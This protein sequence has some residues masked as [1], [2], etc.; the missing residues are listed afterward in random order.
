MVPKTAGAYTVFVSSPDTVGNTGE[1]MARPVYQYEMR[2]EESNI[3]LWALEISY[4]YALLNSIAY[5]I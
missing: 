5:T 3:R 4:Q 2:N 1:F